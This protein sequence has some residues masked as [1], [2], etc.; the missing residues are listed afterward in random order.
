MLQDLHGP[1]AFAHRV[2]SV[3]QARVV[4]EAQSDQLLLLA[5]QLSHSDDEIVSLLDLQRLA[6][7]LDI[8]L[9]FLNGNARALSLAIQVIRSEISRDSIQPGRDGRARLAI[10]ADA[11]HG[12]GEDVAGDVFG[13]ADISRTGVSESAHLSEVLLV[14]GAP[15]C[16]VER[17]E[18]VNGID[19]CG[20]LYGGS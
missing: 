13:S 5:G 12:C 3:F 16:L 18:P 17:D 20:T 6:G 15:C 10:A 19:D 11:S 4:E 2:G 1:N 14:E 9:C 8:E 7:R